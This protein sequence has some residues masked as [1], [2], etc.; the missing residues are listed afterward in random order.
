MRFDGTPHDYYHSL[1]HTRAD[2]YHRK[3]RTI[4]VPV[5]S[6][7]ALIGS[8]EIP[9]RVG[10]LKIDTEGHDL[11]VLRGAEEMLA[12]GAIRFVYVEFNDLQPKTGTT[13]GALYPMDEL[14]RRFGF[15]FVASYNDLVVAEGG[16]FGVS[17]ALFAAPPGL[18]KS[19]LT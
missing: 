19:E 6:L 17:N 13:G 3:G 14:L 8:A 11:A 2:R 9:K 7:D 16:L 12:K 1:E 15:Q 5:V 4:E 18:A 10:F